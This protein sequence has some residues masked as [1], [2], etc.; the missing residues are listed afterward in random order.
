MSMF[1]NSNQWSFD[2]PS[3]L[4]ASCYNKTSTPEAWHQAASRT[5]PEPATPMPAKLAAALIVAAARAAAWP[6]ALPVAAWLAVALLAAAKL[7]AAWLAAAKLVA[8]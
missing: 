7:V 2:N 6:V 5:S 1:I 8:A 3:Q 4:L